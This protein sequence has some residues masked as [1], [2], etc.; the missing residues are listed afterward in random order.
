MS[1]GFGR[2][3][4]PGRARL[5]NDRYAQPAPKNELDALAALGLEIRRAVVK[6]VA[7]H[8]AGRRDRTTARPASRCKHAQRTV[9]DVASGKTVRSFGS[10]ALPVSDRSASPPVAP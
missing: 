5:P 9:E 2:Q 8:T 10:L 4:K 1:T 7:A 3:I 6:G